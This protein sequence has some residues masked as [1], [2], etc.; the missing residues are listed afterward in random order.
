[1]SQ[2]ARELNSAVAHFKVNNKR[3]DAS[4]IKTAHALWT[5]KLSDLLAG[6][7]SLKPGDV[8]RHT[9]CKFGQWYDGPESKSL[10][11]FPVF[12]SIGEQHARFHEL[13]RQIAE[14]SN[15]GRKTEAAQKLG[16]AHI[17]SQK[18]FGL[19]DDL[20]R[21]ASAGIEIAAAARQTVPAT[22]LPGTATSLPEQTH[23]LLGQFKTGA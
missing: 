18:L 10:A 2:V 21:V 7:I 1:M 9:E 14:L 6:R 19:L 12:H 16:E 17:L 5:A 22:A 4:P 23:A 8:A 13:A 11:G 3:F 20:E 15:H